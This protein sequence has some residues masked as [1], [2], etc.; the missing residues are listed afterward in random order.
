MLYHHR[1]SK[2]VF[3]FWFTGRKFMYHRWENQLDFTS[4]RIDNPSN[5]MLTG[6]HSLAMWGVTQVEQDMLT[7]ICLSGATDVTPCFYLVHIEIALIMFCCL[8]FNILSFLHVI[9]FYFCYQHCVFRFLCT[10][11]L[12]C[13]DSPII[14][15]RVGFLYIKRFFSVADLMIQKR[16]TNSLAQL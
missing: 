1:D 5:M 16:E 8:V 14:D 6:F 15:T 13:L 2:I 12:M 3:N 9:I 7:I 11:F 10:S 4:Y